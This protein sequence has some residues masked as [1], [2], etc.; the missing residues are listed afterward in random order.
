MIAAIFFSRSD[1]VGAAGAVGLSALL[2][3][4]YF[5][6]KEIAKNRESMRR[7]F[8]EASKVL[9][10]TTSQDFERL[11]V[12]EQRSFNETSSDIGSFELAFEEMVE[13]LERR[14]IVAAVILTLQWA[15]GAAIFDGCASLIEKLEV[16][17]AHA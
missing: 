3:Y 14:E 1:L 6:R 8:R 11:S 5:Q 16:A 2:P 12:D 7:H 17:Y 13:T 9:S 15:F 10:R 4:V